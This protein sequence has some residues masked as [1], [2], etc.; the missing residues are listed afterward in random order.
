MALD[1]TAAAPSKGP[2]GK[3][4]SPGDRRYGKGARQNRAPFQES[5]A[6]APVLVA[7]TTQKGRDLELILDLLIGEQI[8]GRLRALLTARR[9]LGLGT[10]RFGTG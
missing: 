8:V 1:A 4:S 6:L 5:M 2:A 3:R 10:L 7:L 9:R